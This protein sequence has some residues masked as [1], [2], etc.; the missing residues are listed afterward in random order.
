MGRKH[1]LTQPEAVIYRGLFQ[2]PRK[3]RLLW[4]L[5]RS[6]DALLGQ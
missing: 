5:D 1:H 2:L 3:L 4:T 6:L